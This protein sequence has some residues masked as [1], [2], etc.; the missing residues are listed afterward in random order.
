[1]LAGIDT[2]LDADLLH[3]TGEERCQ[4][5][6]SPEGEDTMVM[7]D[8]CFTG[9]HMACLNPPL[10]EVP[11]GVWVCPHCRD[12]SFTEERLKH[13]A[14]ARKAQDDRR[15]QAKFNFPN[16]TIR[17]QEL[18]AQELGGRLCQRLTAGVT[19]EDPHWHYAKLHYMGQ[20][21]RPRSLLLTSEGG[22]Y[23]RLSLTN[24]RS[25]TRTGR[26]RLL[27]SKAQLPPGVR[28]PEAAALKAS[29]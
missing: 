28:I 26:L 12:A 15:A 8:N 18:Q 17:W 22:A 29:A 2:T 14:A 21:H 13:R 6:H 5:C 16:A 20:E 19:E 24:L 3:T 9:W 25:L 7:C 10:P 23:E 11:E 1:L 4:I 27:G